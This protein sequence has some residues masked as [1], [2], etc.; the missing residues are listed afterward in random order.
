MRAGHNM[1]HLTVHL[2]RD[3]LPSAGLALAEIG[4]FVPD[5]RPLCSE[6]LPEVPGVTYRERIRRARSHL[7]RLESLQADLNVPPVAGEG[8]PF[9]VL[10]RA[11][12]V[13]VDEWLADAWKHCS[14]TEAKL[15]EI[16]EELGELEQLERSLDDFADLDVNLSHLQQGGNK[17]LDLRIGTV[18]AENVERLREALSMEQYLIVR[19]LGK[20]ETVRVAIAGLRQEDAPIGNILVAAGFQ[21]LDIPASFRESPEKVRKMLQRSRAAIEKFH[22]QMRQRLADWVDSNRAELARARRLLDAAEPYVELGESARAHGAV[23][24]LQGWLP[25]GALIEAESLL[26][27]QL[28]EP[29]VI[30]TRR[31]RPDERHL[32][33]VPVARS[34]LLKPFAILMQQYGVPRFGEFDPTILFAVTFAAMFGMMFGDVGHGLVFVA[35]GIALRR[36]LKEFT[37]LFIIAG[38]MATLFGFLYGSIF[39]VEHWLHPLWMSPMSDPMYMLTLAFGWGVAF[40]SLGSFIAI[41]NRLVVGD[42]IGALFDPGGVFSLV[43]YYALLGGLIVMLQGGGWPMVATM[44]IVLMLGLLMAYQWRELEAPFAERLLTVIIET[45]EIVNGYVSGSLSFLRVA[46]FALNHVALSIAVFTLADM[47]DG[48]G[49]W[50]MIVGGNIFIIVL[51]GLIV[52]IQTLRLEYYEGFS[53]YFYADGMRYKPLR[54][55]SRIIPDSSSNRLRNEVSS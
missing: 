36:K 15:Q 6:Q 20:G 19:V 9:L 38:L 22:H 21:S 28:Q 53:R 27:G 47:M 10:R 31:P 49:H 26:K 4:A 25:A 12:L 54:T 33:P 29:F 41:Y 13:E 1:L 5:N 16:Q 30:E 34:L 46:A 48:I 14:P 2:M 39:G 24:I 8:D 11:Q 52:S 44:L 23:A 50:A 18:P 51:E 17:Y 40:L 7:D 3:D 45:F 32:V 42:L 55:R 37:T 43:M 35:F